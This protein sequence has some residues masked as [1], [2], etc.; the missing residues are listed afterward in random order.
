MARKLPVTDALAELGYRFV[1]GRN[2][3]ASWSTAEVEHFIYLQGGNAISGA[4]PSANFGLRNLEAEAFAVECVARY[5]WSF[6]RERLDLR[7]KSACLMRSNFSRLDPNYLRRWHPTRG[8]IRLD[9][10]G[11]GAALKIS[12]QSKLLPLVQSLT[13]KNHLLPVL[14]GDDEPFRWFL[15]N[16]A[17]RAAMV[18]ALGAQLGA[19]PDDIRCQL[20]SKDKL[21]ANGLTKY[22]PFFDAPENYV[23][24]I[25]EDWT[26]R[27]SPP[28]EVVAELPR[29]AGIAN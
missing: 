6:L 25:Q 5:G 7:K 14:L 18:V 15:T 20:R 10:P 17:L 4:P 13:S 3:R 11:F 22:S 9:D 26:V 19:Q 21:I 23:A 24:K 16:G 27:C 12:V 29:K 2:Y 1:E 28:F 8:F